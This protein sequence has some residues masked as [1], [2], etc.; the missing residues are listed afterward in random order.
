[1]ENMFRNDN[2]HSDNNHLAFTVEGLGDVDT[3]SI[4][5]VM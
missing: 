1:M 3:I 5:S 2:H 4:V